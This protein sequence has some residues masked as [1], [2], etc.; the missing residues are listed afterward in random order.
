MTDHPQPGS[1]L[2]ESIPFKIF[3]TYSG[4]T[5]GFLEGQFL[6]RFSNKYHLFLTKNPN[7]IN[8]MLVWIHVGLHSCVFPLTWTQ[9][10]TLFIVSPEILS[11]SSS[12]SSSSTNSSRRGLFSGLNKLLNGVELLLEGLCANTTAPNFANIS[13]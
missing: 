4:L 10:I 1:K 12:S 5:T 6:K 8:P 9:T 13:I 3:I 11:C 7:Q 2:S